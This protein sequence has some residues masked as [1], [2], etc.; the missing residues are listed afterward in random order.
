MPSSRHPPARKKTND[1][2]AAIR[3]NA[4]IRVLHVYLIH[5][6]SQSMRCQARE[7]RCLAAQHSG[8]G[9]ARPRRRELNLDAA[10]EQRSR[11]DAKAENKAMLAL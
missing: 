11:E 4:F 8:P 3:S 7:L 10:V 6:V 9:T 2:A 1:E 5:F